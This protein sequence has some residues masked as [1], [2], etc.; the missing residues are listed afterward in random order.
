MRIIVIL[1]LVANLLFF[2]Y[3]RLD[4]ASEGEAIRLVQQ[5]QPEKIKLLTPQQVAAL[6]A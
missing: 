2:T 6:R 5:V 4:A 3:T 1:L